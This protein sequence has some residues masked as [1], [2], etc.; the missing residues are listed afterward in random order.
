MPE[1]ARLRLTIHA[2]GSTCARR[3]SSW[4]AAAWETGVVSGSVTTTTRVSV[5]SCRRMSGVVM[6]DG[7]WSDPRLR[8]VCRW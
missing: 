2:K 7:F 4:S 8:I 5:G 3:R 6:R 1:A